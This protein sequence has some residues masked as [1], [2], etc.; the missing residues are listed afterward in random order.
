MLAFETLFKEVE[1]LQKELKSF[2]RGLISYGE[3]YH[4]LVN[5]SV[6]VE[7][8]LE[9]NQTYLTNP[10]QHKIHFT[11]FRSTGLHKFTD[12]TFRQKGS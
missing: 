3:V 1:G 12:D 6:L 9:Y 8:L 10:K 5:I 2:Q 4:T 11:L 7:Y